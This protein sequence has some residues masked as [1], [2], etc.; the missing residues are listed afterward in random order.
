MYKYP[1]L[2]IFGAHL[3]YFLKILSLFYTDFT[4][5]Q[6]ESFLHFSFGKQYCAFFLFMPSQQNTSWIRSLRLFRCSFSSNFA[7]KK[8]AITFASK[9]KHNSLFSLILPSQGL[10]SFILASLALLCIYSFIEYSIYLFLC[11]L[12][13]FQLM[14]LLYQIK[15]VSDG[16]T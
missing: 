15:K 12:R 10:S 11:L 2:Y 8:T 7:F 13:I 5:Y 1:R 14:F 3:Y 16:V 9:W 6:F 4:C